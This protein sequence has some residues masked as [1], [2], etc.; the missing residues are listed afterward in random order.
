MKQPSFVDLWKLDPREY[1]GGQLSTPKFFTS[2]PDSY[3]GMFSIENSTKNAC[4]NLDWLEFFGEGYVPLPREKKEMKP[5]DYIHKLSDD[6]FLRYLGYGSSNFK[7]IFEV[8]VNGES[9]ADIKAHPRSAKRG[10]K[11]TSFQIAI[12]NHM[13]YTDYWKNC[14]DQI[15]FLLDLNLNSV[16]RCDIAI[17][18][19]ADIEKMLN[20]YFKQTAKEKYINKLGKA[21]FTPHNL[22][23]KTM[24]VRSFSIGS[25]KSD[26]VVSVYCKSDELEISNKTYI[27]KYWERSGL[28][29]AGKVHRIEMRFKSKYLKRIKNFDWQMLSDKDYLSSLMKTGCENFFEFTWNDNARLDRQS[30]ICV[31]PW[32]EL[33][34]IV[35]EKNKKPETSDRYKAKLAIH[36]FEKMLLTGAGGDERP[37]NLQETI[38]FLVKL[39]DLDKWYI[40]KLDEWQEDYKPQRVRRTRNP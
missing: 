39:Y 18:G 5:E 34:G 21:S 8:Y 25:G 24:T 3:N 14:L 38:A 15:V 12:K 40:R 7:A 19:V 17:D 37:D 27:K 28:N 32:E 4:I 35:L 22:D 26:K 29:V 30:K 1:N 23:N 20:S 16:T 36:L 13:L 33:G 9:F 11:E 31:I 10:F 6:V 2:L